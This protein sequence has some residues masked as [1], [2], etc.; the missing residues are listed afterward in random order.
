[1]KKITTFIATICLFICSIQGQVTLTNANFYEAEDSLVTAR[2]GA[3]AIDLGTTGG[4]QNWD[5]TVLDA[6][7]NNLVIVHPAA[8]GA[9]GVNFPSADIVVDEFGE[10]YYEVT[11]T[12]MRQVGF[13]GDIM[14]F[15]IPANFNPAATFRKAP[16]NYLDTYSSTGGFTVSVDADQIP[17]LDSLSLPITP[18]SLRLVLAINEDIDV[19]AWG[20]VQ[21]PGGSYECLRLHRTGSQATTIEAYAFGFWLDVTDLVIASIPI[22]GLGTFEIDRYE[23]L[24]N[25]AKESIAIANTDPALGLVTDVTFKA[26]PG[27]T[28]PTFNAYVG[29]K[30]FSAYP[31]PAIG[32]VKIDVFG[33][34]RGDYA[35]RIYDILGRVVMEEDFTINKDSTLLLDIGH[36]DKGTYLYSLQ[37]SKEENL[38]SKRLVVIRP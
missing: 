24:S 11:T 4:P 9:G 19:D 26:S 32:E 30:T 38:I 18:D 37:N 21:L 33:F 16:L 14:G 8:D 5:F 17:F 6:S 27:G 22:P 23:F 29:R 1:M 25:D 36:L 15:P 13:Y 12:E 2:D 3:P 7:E 31:N 34:D 28:V 10:V 20:T 35:I